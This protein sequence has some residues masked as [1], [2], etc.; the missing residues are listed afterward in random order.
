M[1]DID[2]E[3]VR[4]AAMA[5]S[6]GE[7]SSLGRKEI[8]AHLNECELCSEEMESLFVIDEI[9]KSQN[10]MTIQADVWPVISERLESKAASASFRWRLVLLFGIPLFGYKGLSLL[11]QTTPSLWSKLV[12]VFLVIGIFTYLRT[13]P[14]KINSELTLSGELL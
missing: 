3:S 9:F 5:L 1:T 10:R 13:N 14:F 4:L 11:L 8:E 12:P 2:C 6:D 7:S